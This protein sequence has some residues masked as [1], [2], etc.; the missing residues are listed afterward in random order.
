MC[1][2]YYPLQSCQGCVPPPVEPPAQRLAVVSP[3]RR[4]FLLPRHPHDRGDLALPWPPSNRAELSRSPCTPIETALSCPS[5]HD[6]PCADW[7]RADAFRSAS[8][9]SV[10]G[11]GCVTSSLMF[12]SRRVVNNFGVRLQTQRRL[13]HE[14][15]ICGAR[16][17]AQTIART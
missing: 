5:T 11:R 16:Y 3:V 2:G 9:R 10:N 12:L 7:M 1:K 15:V 8:F 17:G 14:A 4:A 13:A 6:Q